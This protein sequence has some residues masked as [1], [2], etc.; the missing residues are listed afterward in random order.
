MKDLKKWLTVSLLI[1]GAFAIATQTRSQDIASDIDHSGILIAAN[2]Y[3]FIPSDIPAECLL[4]NGPVY[5]STGTGAGGANESIYYQGGTGTYGSGCNYSSGIYIADDFTVP[6]CT[7]WTIS[8]IDFYSYQTNSGTTSPITGVYV[9]VWNGKPGVAGSVVIWGNFST[10]YLSSTT[11]ANIYRVLSA[12]GGVARPVMKVVANTPGLT[13]DAG[14]YWIEWSLTGSAS[15]SGPWA[16]P[17]VTGG[18]VT[19][20]AVQTVDYGVTY[21]DIMYNSYTQGMPFVMT[22]TSTVLYP[23]PTITGTTTICQ[24]LSGFYSTEAGMSGYLWSVSLGNLITGGQGSDQV[25]VSWLASGVQWISVTYTNQSGCVP[26]TP[27]QL[28]VVVD[29][30]PDPAGYIT[31]IS[32]VCAG[33]SGIAYSVAPVNGAISYIWNI[34]YGASIALG[35][36]T[37]NIT[38]DFSANAATGPITVAGNN[39][40]GNGPPSPEFN[41]TVDPMPATP[42]ITA[43]GLLLISNAYVGNQWYHD[44]DLIPDATGQTYTVPWYDLGCYWTVV[45]V[46]GC[47]SYPSNQ[48]Y[49]YGVGI[50]DR[51]GASDIQIY[52]NPAYERISFNNTIRGDVSILGLSGKLYIQQE[53]SGSPVLINITDLPNGIYMIRVVGNS[54]VQVGKFVKN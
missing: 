17:V 9:R 23:V 43:D 27:T 30:F 49:I 38:V 50:D 44:G 31:G 10:N 4:D 37:N 36:W 20:N 8:S 26:T 25:N 18:N 7:N 52:P 28:S 29:P 53:F 41:L 13:L 21:T 39:L 5:N 40:C 51:N 19:G 2:N 33:T 45:T 12:N 32:Q 46:N 15:F 24:G 1:T 34:P 14:T 35:E 6:S 3:Q 42:T 11:F 47:S 54:G 16:T 48:I 22:G